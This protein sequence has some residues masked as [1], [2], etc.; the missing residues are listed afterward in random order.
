[1]EETTTKGIGAAP[2]TLIG[3]IL[4]LVTCHFL[5]GLTFYDRDN[6]F[7]HRQLV[8]IIAGAIGAA[9]GGSGASLRCFVGPRSSTSAYKRLNNSVD[10]EPAL[11]GIEQ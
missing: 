8:L 2:A 9:M 4:A 7:T 11:P 5:T 10:A 1:M 3:A 6:G